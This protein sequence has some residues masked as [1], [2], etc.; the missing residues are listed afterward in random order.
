MKFVGSV[1]VAAVAL[2]AS[3]ANGFQVVSRT[4]FRTSSASGLQM[5]SSYEEQLKAY[6]QKS[7]QKTA[8][9]EPV[10]GTSEKYPL[11]NANPYMNA[12]K[13]GPIEVSAPPPA[14]VAQPAPVVI[15][16]ES[17]KGGIGAA[18]VVFLGMPLW[19]LLAYNIFFGG[20]LNVG[21]PS[22][23]TLPSNM[24][25]N[26]APSAAKP[27]GVVVMSQPITKAEVRDLFNLWNSA[28]Q[29]L[30]PATVAK[31]Y[32]KD[33]VL[34]PTLSDVPRTDF[35][36]IKDYFVG[37]LKKKPVGKILEGEIFVGNNWA[38]DAGIYEFTFE[39]G[40]KV[41]ARYSFVYAFEDGQW[42]ISHHHSSLMPEEVVRPA[43]ITESEV[44]GLF[45]LWNNALATGD[46]Q[47]VAARYSKDAVLLPTLSDSAR[48]TNER[49]ADYFVGF[50]KKKPK[51]EILEG[52]VK[53]GPNWA[54]DA[55][56][57][58]A[59]V[60]SPLKLFAIIHLLQLFFMLLCLILCYTIIDFYRTY[61]SGCTA[62][63]D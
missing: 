56:K 54:Q 52:N 53:I 38:Q 9:A 33:G 44:R 57:Y 24:I 20:S 43:K 10:N 16:T 21:S 62:K 23:M 15:Q 39:D 4:S 22:E 5:S 60:L 14:K 51:G 27:A 30:D 47:Q 49:I 17:P 59:N 8:T 26:M 34:L 7:Q 58:F 31:R 12:Q 35:N 45:N 2:M 41:K 3:T 29:T 37:F 6:A 11:A 55:G 28:L 32:A 48:Y 46:P 50:L 25:T 1:C 42:M 18:G 13:A 19:L 40:S 36:G 61:I 63:L